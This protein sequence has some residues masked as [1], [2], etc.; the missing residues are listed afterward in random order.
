MKPL[1]M[2]KQSV[3]GR[4]AKVAARRTHDLA[5]RDPRVAAEHI[6]ASQRAV[7]RGQSGCVYCA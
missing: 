2:L 4:L 5:L 3:S 7:D 6:H 1:S